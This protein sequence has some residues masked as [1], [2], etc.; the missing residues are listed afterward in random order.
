MR[1]RLGIAIAGIN[2]EL[3]EVVLRDKPSQMLSLSAKGTVPV[4]ALADGTIIDE[5]IDI[6]KWALTQNDP[7]NWLEPAPALAEGLISHNDG[8][9]KAALDAYKY[10]DRSGL[11]EAEKRTA[12]ETGRRT[13]ADLNA[14]I[15]AHGGQLLDPHRSL[16][17]IAI[18]P[19][20]RQFANTDK[21]WFDAQNLPALQTWLAGHLESALFQSIMH[22][23]AQWKPG[24]TP[25]RFPMQI[26]ACE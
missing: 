15:R 25:P 23:Y 20:I 2:V 18:F 26:S 19:F 10:A 16:A 17:D 6:L 21:E 7:E 4:L 5:S 3:R 1:A 9:F 22:K 12:R 11:S 24:S 14:R 13:L 8:A